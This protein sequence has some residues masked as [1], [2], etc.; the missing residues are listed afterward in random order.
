VKVSRDID[1]VSVSG[2]LD[3]DDSKNLSLDAKLAGTTSR[4]LTALCALR[5]GTTTI[6]GSE[7][8][9]RRPMAGLHDALRQLGAS[10]VSRGQSGCLPVEVARGSNWGAQIE[11]DASMSSQFTSALMMIAPY[12]P[13]GLEIELKENVVSRGYIEMTIG[14]MRAF[15]AQTDISGN[16]IWIAPG[17]Y[18]GTSY[19]V[20]PDASSASYPLAAVAISGGQVTIAGLTRNSL[21]SDV[22]FADLLAQMGCKVS[23]SGAGLQVSRDSNQKLNGITVDMSQISDCV[24]TLA[25]VALFAQSS[26]VITGVEFIRAKE[27]D[28]IGDLA[29]ELRKLGANIKETQDGMVISPSSLSA[30]SLATHHDHRLAMAF[31]LLSRGL[32]GLVVQN[33][34]VVSKSWPDYFDALKAFY[35]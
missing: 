22:A 21:Q 18:S 30:A 4:F 27:S 29:G 12:F 25:V 3:L 31:G 14:V 20:E 32:P 11:I 16:K 2:R 33:P 26:T 23:Q 19:Q 28:R 35:F 1:T 6:D 13:R 9:R 10:V 7:P 5:N 34:E 15:G 8:L 24:P 17:R